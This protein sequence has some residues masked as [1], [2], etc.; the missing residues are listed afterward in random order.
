MKTSSARVDGFW[1]DVYKD[2]ITSVSKR[3]ANVGV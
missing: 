2:L 3:A 1:R